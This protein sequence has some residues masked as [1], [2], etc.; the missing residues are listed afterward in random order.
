MEDFG[1]DQVAVGG[2]RAGEDAEEPGE[3][4]GHGGDRA[5]LDDEEE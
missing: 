3:G 5:G 4:D 1:G 2:D